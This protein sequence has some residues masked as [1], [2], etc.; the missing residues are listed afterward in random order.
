MEYLLRLQYRF[1]VDNRHHVIFLSYRPYNYNLGIINKS[2]ALGFCVAGW[3]E[4]A[5]ATLP[6]KETNFP[7]GLRGAAAAAA[8]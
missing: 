3:V 1:I 5:T 4:V 2:S 6:L 7:R 8:R